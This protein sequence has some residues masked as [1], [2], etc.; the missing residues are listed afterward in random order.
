MSLDF[1]IYDGDTFHFCD[2]F[3]LRSQKRQFFGL[4]E[5]F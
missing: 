4:C 3:G 5:S 2:V 1:E